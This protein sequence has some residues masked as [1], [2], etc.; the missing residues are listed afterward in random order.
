MLY[1]VKEKPPVT[2]LSLMQDYAAYNAWANKTMAE[3]LSAKP[4][5]LLEQEVISSFPSLKSTLLHIWDC[6]RFWLSVLQKALPP[7]SFRENYEGSI[8]DI[9]QGIAGHSDEFAAY[10]N[11]LTETEL[12]E[13]CYFATPWIDGTRPRFEFIHHC[14]N[15]STYHRG[16]LVTIARNVGLNDIPMTDYAY[17]LLVVKN[18]QPLFAPAIAS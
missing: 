9:L 7:V 4:T 10:L 5:S 11:N 3:W 18:Q 13:N 6:Q 17:Y 1:A 16:Q 12:Q 2:L 15:H 8:E 14:M